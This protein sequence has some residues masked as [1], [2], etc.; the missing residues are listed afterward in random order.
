[1]VHI[2]GLKL[3]FMLKEGCGLDIVFGA[4]LWSIYMYRCRLMVHITGLKLYFM[5]K[6]G[7]GWISGLVPS[8]GPYTCIGVVGEPLRAP[9]KL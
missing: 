2:T 9:S 1:M 7:V 8:Y 6:E 5:L 4:G 3:Y